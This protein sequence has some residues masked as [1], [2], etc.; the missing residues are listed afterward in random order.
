MERSYSSYIIIIIAIFVS[1]VVCRNYRHTRLELALT[2]QTTIS[3]T[4]CATNETPI[5]VHTAGHIAGKY[6]QRRMTIRRTWK[7]EAHKHGLRV[8]FVIGRPD[9]RLGQNETNRIQRQLVKEADQYNDILQFNFVENYY[10]LTL[11][12]IAELRW[13]EI[14]CNRSRHLIKVDDD[15]L[16]NIPYLDAWLQ[17]G[18]LPSGM[19]GRMLNTP[20]NRTPGHKWYMPTRYYKRHFYRFLAGFGYILSMDRLKKIL[21][22]I[23]NFRGPILDIDDLF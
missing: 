1:M 23:G 11:K 3:Q 14:H 17:K 7:R 15:V 19:I 13:A 12:A 2:N 16:L 9:P 8:I 20:A 21:D 22:T 4:D 10:N 18:N 5:F 6:F